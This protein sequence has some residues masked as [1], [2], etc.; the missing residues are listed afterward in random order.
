LRQLTSTLPIVFVQVADP[1]GIGFVGSVARPAGNMTG[2]ADFDTYFAAK[3]A[4]TLKELVPS[5][6]R[7]SVI[8]DPNQANHPA[9]FRAIQ[10]A[11]PVLKLQASAAKVHNGSE[12][13]QTID[14]LGGEADS[15]LVVL[16]GPLNNTHRDTIIRSAARNRVPAV[17]PY[18]YYATEGGLLYYGIDQVDQWSKAAEYA[19]RILRGEKPGDLPVQAPTKY[20]LVINLKTAKALGLTVSPTLLARADAVIE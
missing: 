14:A 1:V 2:F 5:L 20:E 7:V 10:S 13:E 4:E 16:P 6:R 11:A 19:D 12:I 17:Y 3:W 8:L 15:G 18:R 9:F